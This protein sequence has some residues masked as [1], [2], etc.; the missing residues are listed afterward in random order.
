MLNVSL[1]ANS[2]GFALYIWL[3]VLKY[4]KNIAEEGISHSPTAAGVNI[5]VDFKTSPVE[6][7]W[8]KTA[9]VVES[10]KLWIQ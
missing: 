1:C 8:D 4:K 6:E 9:V 3:T 5:W 2:Q 10:N 7:P